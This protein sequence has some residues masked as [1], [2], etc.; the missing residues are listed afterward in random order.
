MTQNSAVFVIATD[1]SAPAE[2]A[3]RHGAA[4]A[5]KLGAPVLLVHVVA[6][7]DYSFINVLEIEERHR[8]RQAEQEAAQT[9]ILDPLAAALK[10]QGVAVETRVEFGHPARIIADIAS[11]RRAAMIVAGTRGRSNVASV[12]LGSF[13]HGLLHLAD[14]PVLLVPDA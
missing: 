6:W 9:Q 13:S 7:S 11:D 4:L 2:A 1:G 5:A 10:G 3:A 8:I 12:L 14:R